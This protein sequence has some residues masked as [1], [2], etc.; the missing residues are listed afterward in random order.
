MIPFNV[1]HIVGNEIK[2]VEQIIE[3]REFCGDKTFT[4][5]CNE[6]LEKT[7]SVN[8]SLLTPS[9]THSLELSALLLNIKEGDEVIMPSY[10]FV[11][12]ANA[13]Y[14]RGAKIVFVDIDPRTMNID[15]KMV[16]KAITNK[17]KAIV[18]V[19]YAGMSCDMDK[20]VKL[21]KDANCAVV[22]DA[23]QAIDARY[24]GKQLGTI[25]DIGC[26]SFH[27]TKN[28]HCGEGGAIF[29]NNSKLVDRSEI[30]REKGTNRSQFLHG[31]VDKYTWVDIGSSFL[32][33]ELSACFLYP[34]LKTVK[35]SNSKR[36]EIW[37]SYHNNLADLSNIELQYV[38]DYCD[39]NAHM[40]FIKLPSEEARNKVLNQMREKGVQCTFHYIPLH[41]SSYG[42]KISRYVS[43]HD[44]TTK[45]AAKLLRLP[46]HTSLKNEDVS[47]ICDRLSQTVKSL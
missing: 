18:P 16:E 3:Q 11:S 41:S 24:K 14:L 33:N 10:T 17:T 38:P 5:K 43:D 35:E 19:H 40:F 30:I 13:F 25:G 44:H 28:I 42:Q 2:N 37:N 45:E 9:C 23:A 6:L 4:K 32:L 46:M 34:Q 31:L 47:F 7:Y 29:V 36:L 26:F 39:H 21:A 15:E 8:K 1:P 12:T 22:E 27:E 20:I